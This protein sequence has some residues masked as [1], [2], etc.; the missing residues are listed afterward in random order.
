MNEHK[1]TKKFTCTCIYQD[2]KFIQ[3][4]FNTI[5]R[6]YIY[7]YTSKANTNYVE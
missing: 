7:I 2:N 3:S 6:I 1:Y 5:K 4:M